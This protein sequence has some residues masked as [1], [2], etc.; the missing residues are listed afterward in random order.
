MLNG[1]LNST[2]GD[3][4]AKALVRHY[5]SKVS[6]ERMKRLQRQK[7]VTIEAG[8]LEGFFA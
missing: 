2:F 6:K 1:S 3:A 7:I 8:Q 5:D 4:M